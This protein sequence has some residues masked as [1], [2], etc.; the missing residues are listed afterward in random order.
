MPAAFFNRGDVNLI[1][2]L[3][4]HKICICSRSPINNVT[5]NYG[6]SVIIVKIYFSKVAKLATSSSPYDEKD[7]TEKDENKRGAHAET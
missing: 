7:N 4:K 2:N 1:P 6:L 3:D 5:I